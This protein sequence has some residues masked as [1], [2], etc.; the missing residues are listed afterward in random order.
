MCQKTGS[1]FGVFTAW[2]Q[3]DCK[4]SN[5][6]CSKMDRR[7]EAVMPDRTIRRRGGE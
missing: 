6:R 5:T 3:G 4:E 2:D 7:A 1:N